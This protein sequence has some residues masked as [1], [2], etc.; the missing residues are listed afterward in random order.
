MD[1]PRRNN[2][3]KGIQARGQGRP[4]KHTASATEEKGKDNAYAKKT[5][6]NKDSEKQQVPEKTTNSKTNWENEGTDRNSRTEKQTRR[7]RKGP[8]GTVQSGTKRIKKRQRI[9]NEETLWGDIGL[10]E[11][12]RE[13]GIWEC[14]I[15][16][17]GANMETT[18][19]I[20]HHR[21]M[22]PGTILWTKQTRHDMSVLQKDA[23]RDGQAIH[24]YGSK[25]AR[26]KME[27]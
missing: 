14:R 12:N 8:N 9:K 5:N 20:S 23:K 2:H 15:D 11:Y 17:C 6:R 7:E 25:T 27:H 21:K 16:D 1:G 18:K 22:P 3:G 10:V 4:E 26:R 13:T 19:R 24:P